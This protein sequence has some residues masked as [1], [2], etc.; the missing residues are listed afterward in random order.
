MCKEV[1]IIRSKCL[2]CKHMGDNGSR[3]LGALKGP[4]RSERIR[5]LSARG[6]SRRNPDFLYE[7][8]LEGKSF[9]RPR[10]SSASRVENSK[11]KGRK[12]SHKGSEAYKNKIEVSATNTE[13]SDKQTFIEKQNKLSQQRIDLLLASRDKPCEIPR[14]SDTYV[15]HALDQR[16]GSVNTASEEDCEYNRGF[17]D[18]YGSD[19]DCIAQCKEKECDNDNRRNI[20]SASMSSAEEYET[21]WKQ[22][23]E[24]MKKAMK[25]EV[26]AAKE[27][28]L[29]TVDE[30]VS[31]VVKEKTAS[32]QVQK[33][34]LGP[35]NCS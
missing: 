18:K 31:A 30:K 5:N 11:N 24:D 29:K 10:A 21:Q 32:L 2:N 20:S 4:K 14:V 3:D 23:L 8:E 34:N 6:V 12:Q 13:T 28:I 27:E 17:L 22:L 35:V 25:T 19:F 26:G 16:E 1:V 15:L 33:L 9:I 7:F